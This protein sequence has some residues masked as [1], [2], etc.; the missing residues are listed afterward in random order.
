MAQQLPLLATICQHC[1]EVFT[2]FCRTCFD[3]LAGS[4][5][6]DS[7]DSNDWVEVDSVDEQMAESVFPLFDPVQDGTEFA[8]SQDPRKRRREG[9]LDQTNLSSETPSKSK[10]SVKRAQSFLR[11]TSAS[12]FKKL[13]VL[14]FKWW[15]G[16]G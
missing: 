10:T 8:R 13:V 15:T 11:K 7:Q 16:S 4:I 14:P 9:A 1:G 6:E 3:P 12:A 2:G 5:Y